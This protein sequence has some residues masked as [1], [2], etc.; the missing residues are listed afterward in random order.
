MNNYKSRKDRK[1]NQGKSR[2]LWAKG[3]CSF[4]LD[5]Q[6]QKQKDR[7]RNQGKSRKLWAKGWKS[8]YFDEDLMIG[9][10]I[11]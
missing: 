7:K 4:Y 1:S 3:G 9:K 5:E 8:L 10:H 11:T 6:L 2:K